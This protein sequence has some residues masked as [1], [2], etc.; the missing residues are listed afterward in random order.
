MFRELTIS[1]ITSNL[2][3][4]W[5]FTSPEELYLFLVTTQK[6][7]IELMTEYD[8]IIEVDTT[9]LMDW[10]DCNWNKVA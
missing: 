3:P 7:L 8:E 5:T 10:A 6:T 9:E 2:I 4:G 1:D